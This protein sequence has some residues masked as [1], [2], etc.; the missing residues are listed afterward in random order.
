MVAF[1]KCIIQ[2]LLL[3]LAIIDMCRRCLQTKTVSAHPLVWADSGPTLYAGWVISLEEV[4]SSAEV[5]YY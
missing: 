3:E 2:L 5:C 1:N 4:G